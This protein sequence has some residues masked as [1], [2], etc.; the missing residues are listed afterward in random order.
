MI[1]KTIKYTD[2]NGKENEDTFYFNLNKTELTKM[3]LGT[4]N[5][6][7]SYIKEAVESGDNASLMDLFERLILDSYGIKSEDGKR[8]IKSKQLREEFEQSAAYSELFME[9]ATNAD[10]AEAFVK[11]VTNQ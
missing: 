11:G 2:F 10:S 6:M 1:K 7:S 4:K 3:E 9:I 5:G 8:F